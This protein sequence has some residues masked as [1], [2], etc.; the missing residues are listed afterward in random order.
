MLNLAPDSFDL[1]FDLP[2]LVLAAF[3]GMTDILANDLWLGVI[4][5]GAVECPAWLAPFRFGTELGERL[6]VV[7]AAVENPFLMAHV[8]MWLQSGD[9]RRAMNQL[10]CTRAA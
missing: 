5:A 8:A 2:D 4:L 1:V 6:A 9:F 3:K 7:S 10:M